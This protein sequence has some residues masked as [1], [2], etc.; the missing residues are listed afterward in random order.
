MASNRVTKLYKRTT[1]LVV[2]ISAV[3]LAVVGIILLYVVSL[4][5][6]W[7]GH[8]S[9]QTVVRDAASL[10]LVTGTITVIWQLLGKREFQ[11]ELF[12]IARISEEIRSAGIIA[13]TPSF[14]R[15]IDWDALFAGVRQLDVFFAYGRTWRATHDEEL[16]AIAGRHGATIRVVL[17]DPL[18]RPTVNELARRFECN[19]DELQSLIE[20]AAQ[21]FRDLGAENHGTGATVGIW[22]LPAAPTFSFYFFDDVALLAFYTHRRERVPVP[23]FLLARGGTLYDFL[24]QEFAAMISEE[25]GLA[26]P[27]GEVSS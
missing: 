27:D 2:W 11:N 6:F 21:Y 14:L 16:K 26:R 22:F 12:A 15:N 20:A 9:L 3:A 25:N 4:D 8:E 23:A 10:F 5:G 1:S 19:R 24:H 7:A 13:Y 17:P 18:D